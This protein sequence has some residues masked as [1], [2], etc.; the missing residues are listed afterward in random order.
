MYAIRFEVARSLVNTE[1]TTH[2]KTGEILA[3]EQATHWS[4]INDEPWP[5]ECALFQF[6]FSSHSTEIDRMPCGGIGLPRYHGYS[7]TVWLLSHELVLHLRWTR[8]KRNSSGTI[9]ATHT[10]IFGPTILSVCSSRIVSF[11]LGWTAEAWSLLSKLA[12][13]M[14]FFVAP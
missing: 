5:R 10:Q 3:R 12:R 13:G 9:I 1:C 4:R 14:A 2:K 8:T 11:N 7:S 6:F